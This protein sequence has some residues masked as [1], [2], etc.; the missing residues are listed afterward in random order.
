MC[1]Q[2]FIGKPAEAAALGLARKS[3]PSGV[4]VELDYS[5]KTFEKQLQKADRSG[6]VW[7]AIIGDEEARIDQLRLKRLLVHDE[8]SKIALNDLSSIL[9]FIQ[10]SF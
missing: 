3:R 4:S 5:G 7:A 6:A 8:E 9:A 10:C 2:P 1:Q